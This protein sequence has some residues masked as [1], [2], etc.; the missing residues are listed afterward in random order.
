MKLSELL[1]GT[2]VDCMDRASFSVVGLAVD[3]RSVMPGYLFTAVSGTQV[4]GA[5]YVEDAVRNGASVILSSKALKNIS[6]PV[7]THD[8]PRL[9]LALCARNF[10]SLQPQNISAVTGT[11]GKTSVAEF[12]RQIFHA[13]QL[14][15]A[16]IGTLGVSSAG[17][18][19]P[20]AHT[21]PD[22]IQLHALLRDLYAN[23]IDHV[24][25]EASSHGLAQFRLDGVQIKVA[26]FTNL[27]RDHLDYHADY[28]D[29]FSAKA[30]LFTDVLC[31]DG[32]AVIYISTPAGQKMAQQVR[33]SGRR[34]VEVG[35]GEGELQISILATM[36]DGHNIRVSYKDR[37]ADIFFPIAGGF[38]VSNLSVALGMVLES[39]L[40]FD[41]AI[42]GISSLKAPTGRMERVGVTS[43]GA[44]VYVD[45]AHTPD[46]L[47]MALMSARAHLSGDGKIHLVF[48]CGGDRDEG[49]RAEMGRIAQRLAD[50]IVVTDDNPRHEDPVKI[51]QA[52]LAECSSA[53]DIADRAEAIRHAIA[54]AGEADIVLITGK[55]HET[56]QLIGD[57]TFAFSDIEFATSILVETGGDDD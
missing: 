56:G 17:Y 35:I 6:I 30:R 44:N 50:Y 15:S 48:G 5:V 39:G 1:D 28:D 21:T 57:E 16:S 4:D 11:N 41:Q 27:S 29:Y 38:Q 34:V 25:I 53:D 22:P 47:E 7:L 24:T 19:Q 20:L 52:I 12:V 51:R 23:Q 32:C 42:S 46:A 37:S 13:A 55:G 10:F 26:G 45:Y 49:K 2:G 31:Q 3:S 14:P 9:A 43:K 40:S 8:N 18:W 54:S 36:P 33:A